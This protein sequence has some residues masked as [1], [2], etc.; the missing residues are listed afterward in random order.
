ML[1]L[2]FYIG[3]DRYAFGCDRIIEI[4]PR[5]NLKKISHT[6]EYVAGMLNFRGLPVPIVD[7]CY[8]LAGRPSIS[9]LHTRIIIL[10]FNEGENVFTLGLLAERVTETM[11]HKQEEFIDSGIR[12]K[13]VP[14]LGGMLTDKEGVIQFVFLNKLF[15]VVRDVLFA[16][17]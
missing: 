14:Y 7:L 11:L 4:I 10:R 3:S 15:Q 16:K 1:M 17:S 13:D 2:L 9:R 5:V 12:A 6:P 8:L